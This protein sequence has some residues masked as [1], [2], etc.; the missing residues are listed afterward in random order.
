MEGLFIFCDLYFDNQQPYS[1]FIGWLFEKALKYMTQ[2]TSY[3]GH[4][5]INLWF[6]KFEYA[7]FSSS[8]IYD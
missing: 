8:N 3:D 7:D 5:L 4:F 1:T 6:L 2:M